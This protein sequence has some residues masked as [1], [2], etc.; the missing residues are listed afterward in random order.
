MLIT[1]R[2]ADSR[3]RL[4]VQQFQT[5]G[6]LSQDAAERFGTAV[7]SADRRSGSTMAETVILI[8]AFSWSVV[9]LLLT[10]TVVTAPGWEGSVA[11]GTLSLSW[12]GTAT[13][14]FSHPLFLFLFFRW[15][16]RFLV[17]AAL[18]ARISTLDLQLM[19][20]HPDRA[21]GLGFLCLFPGIFSGLVFALSCVVASTMFKAAHFVALSDDVIWMAIAAWIG[22][23]GLLFIGPLVVFVGPLYRARE[24]AMLDYG[25]LAHQHH[26]AF[27]SKWIDSSRTGGE[28]MGSSDPSSI[29]DLNASVQTALDLRAVPIDRTA[30]LELLIAA[31]APFLVLLAART[32]LDQLIHAVLGSIL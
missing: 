23:I 8:L 9:S 14:L 10:S 4:L 26:L 30:L 17:W 5:S 24:R 20:L 22:F 15:I 3:V 21:G 13:L 2:V 32:P 11:D 28:L 16:W 27:I 6:L 25:R 18:L 7:H 19:P 12:A 31:C 1:E 29:S